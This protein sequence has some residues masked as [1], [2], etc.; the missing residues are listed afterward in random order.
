MTQLIKA[1][2]EKEAKPNSYRSLLST[3]N[4]LPAFV[5]ATLGFQILQLLFI[6]LLGLGVWALARRPAPTLVQLAGGESVR[7]HGVNS[8]ERDPA[9]VRKF[10]GEVSSLLFNW[11]DQVS[12]T[13]DSGEKLRRDPGVAV[14][15][16][17][18]DKVTAPAWEASFALAVDF[19]EPFLQKLAKLIPPSVWSGQTQVVLEV[20]HLGEP[21]LLEPGKWKVSQVA[22][23]LIFNGRQPTGQVIPFNKEFYLRAIDTPPLPLPQA[24]TP[25]QRTVYRIR[26]ANLEIYQIEDLKDE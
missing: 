12:V 5:Y 24:A 1:E 23:L 7:V 16:G 8:L 9:A 25:L 19:R 14:G 10:V 6:V 3:K 4:L 15:E 21:E 22:N 18:K 20:S 13:G 17:E 2:L 11:S 26:E